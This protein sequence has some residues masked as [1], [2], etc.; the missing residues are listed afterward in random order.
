MVVRFVTPRTC[1]SALCVAGFRV[2]DSGRRATSHQSRFLQFHVG[3]HAAILLLPRIRRIFWAGFRSARRTGVWRIARFGS[4]GAT[5]RG[6]IK[7]CLDVRLLLVVIVVSMRLL[8]LFLLSFGRE[9]GRRLIVM[10]DG[11]VITRAVIPLMLD[12][13]N[14][15]LII[16]AKKKIIQQSLV[17]TIV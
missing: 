7:V 16:T 8:L 11:R 4:R 14:V 6:V 10:R 15:W 12:C 1:V 2:G 17:I 3:P 9:F 13:V 5:S